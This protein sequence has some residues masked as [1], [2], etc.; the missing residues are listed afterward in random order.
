VP[1]TPEHI[2]YQEEAQLMLDVVNFFIHKLPHGL[3][4][5]AQHFDEAALAST[6]SNR[7]EDLSDGQLAALGVHRDDIPV[8]AAAAGLFRVANNAKAAK[9]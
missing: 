1:K 2:P 9:K 6:F 8:V 3:E 4:M 7:I 5:T